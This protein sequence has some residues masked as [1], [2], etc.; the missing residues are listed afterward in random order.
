MRTNEGTASQSWNDNAVRNARAA[1]N[2]RA[3][4][5]DTQIGDKGQ[6]KIN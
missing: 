1:T 6:I 2:Q 3:T 5:S 4:T